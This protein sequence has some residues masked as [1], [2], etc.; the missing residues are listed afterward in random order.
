MCQINTDPMK[1]Q[2]GFLDIV[3][4]HGSYYALWGRVVYGQARAY[5]SANMCSR[6]FDGSRGVE[7]CASYYNRYRRGRN[8]ARV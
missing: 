1:S 7:D 8:P 6:S 4:E 5:G 2:L 3:G